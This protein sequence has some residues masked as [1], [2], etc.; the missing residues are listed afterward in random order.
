MNAN[1]DG[2][3]ACGMTIETMGS[4]SGSRG[5][6]VQLSLKSNIKIKLVNHPLSTKNASSTKHSQ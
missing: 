3:D 6:N 4:K 5:G 2:K 1:K